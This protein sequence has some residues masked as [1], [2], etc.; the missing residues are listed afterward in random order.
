MPPI[1]FAI[2][3]RKNNVVEFLL[4]QND[5]DRTMDGLSGPII[6]SVKVQN[7]ECTKML[8]DS[9]GG[10]EKALAKAEELGLQ[11]L[12]RHINIFR[13]CYSQVHYSIQLTTVTKITC[14]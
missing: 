6:I 5:I 11:D 8:L 14:K 13:G 1:G 7:F 10:P 3:S 4:K 12:K 2:I 9:L